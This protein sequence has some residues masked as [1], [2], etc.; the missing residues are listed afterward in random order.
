MTSGGGLDCG[1][2]KT[3]CLQGAIDKLTRRN[4]S[5]IHTLH[6]N[7]QTVSIKENNATDERFFICTN[8]L[9]WV[10]DQSEHK[11]RETPR[12]R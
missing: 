6:S 3:G 9:S 10:C 12:V 11:G 2:T 5:G 8:R 4:L 7:S 1:K